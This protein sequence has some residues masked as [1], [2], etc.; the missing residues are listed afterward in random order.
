MQYFILY[1]IV[2]LQTSII[3]SAQRKLGL[4]PDNWATLLSKGPLNEVNSLGSLTNLLV[5]ADSLR[6]FRFLDSLEA[7]DNAKGYDFRISFC[8][9]KAD[10]LY[11]KFAGYDKYKDR[12][13]NELQPIKEQ[14][15]KLYV[16]ALDAAYH[17]EVDLTIGWVSFY[18]ARRMRTFG[19]TGWAVMY[20][21]NGV[22]LFEKVGYPV[23]PPFIRSLP[24][25]CTR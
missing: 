18:S 25:C 9:V 24:N 16:E 14:M 23:E 6:A 3:T 7:S 11:K 2:F 13:S 10:F 1:L 8:M 17:T 22:D 5:E 19:E 15:M 20:E 12:R 4:E 21:K